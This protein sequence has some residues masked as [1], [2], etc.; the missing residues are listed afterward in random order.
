MRT[1]WIAASSVL[2]QQ[3]LAALQV[4]ANHRDVPIRLGSL[5]HRER[6]PQR[7][8]R[9]LD[10]FGQAGDAVADPEANWG[11]CDVCMGS[12]RSAE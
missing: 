2:V 9:L 3:L 7:R 4:S 12:R 6:L 1:L 10:Y 5:K 11:A 8:R